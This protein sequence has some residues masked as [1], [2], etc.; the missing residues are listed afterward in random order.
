MTQ[1]SMHAISVVDMIIN[2][3]TRNLNV[4]ELKL[5]RSGRGGLSTLLGA[6]RDIEAFQ[7]WLRSP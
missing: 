1:F 2:A 7:R 5:S 4:H 3:T 6:R